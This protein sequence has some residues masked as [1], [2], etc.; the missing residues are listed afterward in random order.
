[1]AC[2][3]VVAYIWKKKSKGKL[4]EI[5]VNFSEKVGDMI[6]DHDKGYKGYID[7]KKDIFTIPEL[8][9]VRPVPPRDVFIPTLGGNK[10]INLINFGIDRYG[11]RVPKLHNQVILEKRDED[12]NIIKNNKGKSIYIKHR[13]QFC[14]DVVEPDVKHWAEYYNKELERRHL[15]RDAMFQKWIFPIG[16]G[17]MF[18]FAVVVLQQTTKA[19]QNDKAMIMERAE[20]ME[21]SA[22]KT[23]DRLN[24]LIDKVTGQRVLDNNPTP[25]EEPEP[26]D[27]Q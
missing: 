26:P 18:I 1:M 13:W 22:K 2:F 7:N 3:Y 11:F 19:V 9:I 21:Q 27:N 23:S 17:I 25:P 20:A 4:E 14:D 6:V 8:K 15:S 10:K 24:T 16:M 12:N 5:V